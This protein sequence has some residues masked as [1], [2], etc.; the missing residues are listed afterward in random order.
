MQVNILILFLTYICFNPFLLF[1]SHGGFLDLTK[2][3]N[4]ENTEYNGLGINKDSIKSPHGDLHIAAANLATTSTYN[5]LNDF[6]SII[7]DEKFAKFLGLATEKSKN[8]LLLSKNPQLI[9]HN[10]LSRVK[11]AEPNTPIFTVV[12][13][14]LLNSGKNSSNNRIVFSELAALSIRKNI[15]INFLYANNQN[16]KSNQFAS[17]RNIESFRD[18]ADLSG[19]GFYSTPRADVKLSIF[20]FFSNQEIFKNSETFF[21]ANLDSLN[22]VEKHYDWKILVGENLQSISFQISPHFKDLKFRVY[23]SNEKL[24]QT[25][26]GFNS[27][28]IQTFFINNPLQGIWKVKISSKTSFNL[29]IL[30]STKL[31]MDMELTQS[32]GNP[33][34]VGY[35]KIANSP[36]INTNL[37]LFVTMNQMKDKIYN[38]SVQVVS[39]SSQD[40]YEQINA[41]ILNEF[42]GLKADFKAP[43]K[44]FRLKLVVCTQNS[45]FQRFKNNLFKPT[46]LGIRVAEQ[47]KLFMNMNETYQLKFTIRNY[48]LMNGS[49]LKLQVKDTMNLI[50]HSEELV[51]PRSSK[52]QKSI[53]I[54]VP[55]NQA[56]KNKQNVVTILVQPIEAVNN[57]FQNSETVYLSI[58]ENNPK[59]E[60][61]PT[62]EIIENNRKRSCSGKSICDSKKLW[63]GLMKITDVNEVGFRGCSIGLRNRESRL[64]QLKY[65]EGIF[66]SKKKTQLVG[67]VA[68]CCAK[69]FQVV[70]SDN[71]RNFGKCV[72]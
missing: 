1:L 57:Y 35:A 38:A 44:E 36:V 27:D 54:P 61:N 39:K 46:A 52:I 10:L 34:H 65:E 4:E 69:N 63:L 8:K 14:D 20:E 12:D 45:C 31:H 66:G 28:L 62:C 50:N 26:S 37:S 23:D 17:K 15:K 53:E 21:I 16:L 56:L 68:D 25:Q 32:N 41:T 40:I 51:L 42:G 58:H 48:D 7:G 5:I 24:L 43:D 29:K 60:F 67:V 2:R 64:I 6:W 22:N 71:F 72:F 47:N 55:G 59:F 19:G 30:A 11:S 18:L 70:V 49:R 9:F 33:V 3:V 13:S